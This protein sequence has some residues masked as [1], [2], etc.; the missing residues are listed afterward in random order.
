MPQFL[1][2]AKALPG[3][4]RDG[5]M[6]AENKE[7]AA[8]K[9]R[10]DGL[11]P[12]SIEEITPD[13]VRHRLRRIRQGEV[14]A[15]TS[16]LANLIHA[17]FP[18]AGAL[19]TLSIQE[20][21]V[22]VK[23]LIADLHILIQKGA[24]FSEALGTQPA[25]FS[26]FYL[27]MI[28]IG[29]T[30][31]K[32]DETLDRLAEF[33]ERERELFAQIISALT[34][35]A[36]I[37]CIGLLTVFLMI[38]FFIPRLAGMFADLG[39]NLPALTQIVMTLS[40]FTGAAWWGF[41]A[42]GAAIILFIRASFRSERRRLIIDRMLLGIPLA[43]NVIIKIEMTRL[44]Y[45]LGLLLR[46]GVPMLCALDVITHSVNNRVFRRK[47]QATQIRIRK[48][49]SLSSCLQ[50]EPFFP[51]AL[52][53]M[54]SVGEE[55]GEMAQLLTRAAAAFE[56]DVNRAVKSMVSLIEPALI[57]L[58]GGMVVVLVFAMLLPVFQINFAVR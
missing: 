3:Q 7:S 1:Y 29:E 19:S 21:N 22:A 50:S 2:K 27:N 46:N 40:A 15:F 28:K 45:A 43:G 13:V 56:A 33:K 16:Q 53:N 44:C 47:L 58:I 14:C 51:P 8:R 17:G 52:I 18:L 31:G 11:H 55:S 48:G 38:A 41:A 25:L 35:P 30:T 36:F 34:Y 42:G 54:I 6:H 4:A 37:F 9:L 20:Q 49:E 10:Q 12:I 57:L 26:S 5:V 32:L 39:Q 23:K 24:T